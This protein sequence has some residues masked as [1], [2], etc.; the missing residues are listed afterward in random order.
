MYTVRQNL[1]GGHFALVNVYVPQMVVNGAEQLVESDKASLVAAL[2][3]NKASL[4][5]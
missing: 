4:P 2:R 3:E 5:Q 1:Y